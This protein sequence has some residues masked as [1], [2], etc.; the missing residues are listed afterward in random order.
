[1]FTTLAMTITRLPKCFPKQIN[2]CYFYIFEL[3]IL[4]FLQCKILKVG[5][6][7][8]NVMLFTRGITLTVCLFASQPEFQF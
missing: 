8:S 5:Q 2:T 3:H 1:M 6:K 4:K 7:N